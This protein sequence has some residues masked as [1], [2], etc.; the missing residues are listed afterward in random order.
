MTTLHPYAEY[1]SS[2]IDWLGSIP[3][4]WNVL[5]LGRILARND[6]GAW[7]EDGADEDIEVLRSTEQTVDGGWKIVS[8]ARRLMS[9]RDYAKTRLLA[10]DLVVTTSSGSAAHIGKTSVVTES[11][12]RHGY[13]FSN[14]MQRLRP[15]E[16]LSSRF[17]WYLMNNPVIRDQLVYLSTT[18]T[19]L[20]NLNG[21][22]L[23]SL[24]LPLPPLFEQRA[25]AD[26]LDVAD[27]R[28]TRYIAAKCRM[29]ALLEEQKQAII[30]QAVTRGLDPDVPFKPS[31]VDWLG[32][33]PAHWELRSIKHELKNLNPRRIPLSSTERGQMKQRTY[34]YYGASGPIDMV[35]S[36][37]FDDD[38]LLVAED[39][40][41]LVMRN[42]PLSIIARG[43]FWVNN[44]AHILKPKTGN[45][46][47]FAHLL[48]SIDYRP[49]ISGAA[50]P[51]LT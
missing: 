48:E 14:F 38:L 4:A 47:Y 30:N 10:G 41:N 18:T 37:L 45:L 21:G 23:N 3:A 2:D 32:D 15:S 7:G 46:E 5:K 17:L 9:D 35:E 22:I 43:K 50:Q 40:A 19:G 42:L 44:H 49:W 29:I 39:G 6:S 24:L 33:I 1:K 25:I 13:S 20:A 11:M 12:E 28:I 34:Q 27:A 51:K 8:P 31:G 16:E 36:Y 26:F